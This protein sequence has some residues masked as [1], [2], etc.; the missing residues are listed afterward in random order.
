VRFYRDRSPCGRLTRTVEHVEDANHEFEGDIDTLTDGFVAIG[1]TPE[2]WAEASA[3]VQE[4]LDANDA[5]GFHWYKPDR[6]DELACTCGWRRSERSVDRNQQP[7]RVAGHDGRPL[8]ASDPDL[9]KA[10]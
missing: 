5:V 4:V 1:M 3:I 6:T 7:P 9:L 2:R 8:A 10:G